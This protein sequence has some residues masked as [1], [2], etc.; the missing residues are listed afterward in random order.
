M[1]STID[2]FF[3]LDRGKGAIDAM[4]VI[5]VKIPN[6]ETIEIAASGRSHDLASSIQE[7]FDSARDEVI[8][9]AE[10]FL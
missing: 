1:R 7:A 4:V 6:R 9:Q 8:K 2:R 10:R 5:Q 3:Q